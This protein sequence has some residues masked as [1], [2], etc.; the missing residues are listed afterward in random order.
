MLIFKQNY[1]TTLLETNTV[2][3][4]F[5]KSFLKN[6]WNMELFTQQAAKPEFESLINKDRQK[7]EKECNQSCF[8]DRCYFDQLERSSVL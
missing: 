5:R 4:E 6:P 7:F 2:K 1:Q 8:E 3:P